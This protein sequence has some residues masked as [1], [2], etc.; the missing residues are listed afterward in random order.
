MEGDGEKL[1]RKPKGRMHI[2]DTSTVKWSINH[3]TNNISGY[4]FTSTRSHVCFREKKNYIWHISSL[5]LAMNS[6]L[7]IGILA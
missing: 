1:C 4:K 2:T 7:S 6:C 5:S 3:N